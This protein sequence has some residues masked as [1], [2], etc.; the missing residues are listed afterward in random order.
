MHRQFSH[1]HGSRR[2]FFHS[3][4]KS[5]R[6][7][8]YHDVFIRFKGTSFLGPTCPIF[9][10]ARVQYLIATRF[11]IFLDISWNP[12]REVGKFGSST[13][14]TTISTVLDAYTPVQP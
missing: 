4:R 7:L 11:A 3:G 6:D 12:F 9:M 1:P 13:S 10:S 2:V 8:R 5:S 14:N